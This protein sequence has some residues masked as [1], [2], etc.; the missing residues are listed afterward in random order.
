MGGG[1]LESL[2]Q[3]VGKT[4]Q[5]LAQVEDLDGP[6]LGS[7]GVHKRSPQAENQLKSEKASSLSIF[8][9]EPS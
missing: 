2:P 3:V 8:D 1:T 4:P 6:V 5:D 7:Y 9:L